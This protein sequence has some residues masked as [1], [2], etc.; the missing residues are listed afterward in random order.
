ML[1]KLRFLLIA[2]VLA[3]G[4]LHG[5]P[6]AGATVLRRALVPVLKLMIQRLL[7]YVTLYGL[8][9]SWDYPS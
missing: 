2:V 3:L 8:C 6:A 7:L 1:L 9:R 5:V 4:I